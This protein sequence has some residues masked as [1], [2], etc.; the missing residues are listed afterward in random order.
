LIRRSVFGFFIARKTVQ[1]L[2][3]TTELARRLLLFC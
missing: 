1:R 3:Y 2:A